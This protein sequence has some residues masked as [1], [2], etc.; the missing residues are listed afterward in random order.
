MS[1]TQSG[2]SD[3]ILA[4]EKELGVQLFIR[5]TRRVELTRAGAAFYER[6]VRILSEVS[7]KGDRPL[8]WWEV[9]AQDCDRHRLAKQSYEFTP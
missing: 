2:L 5:S 3:A 1:I 6:S 9:G 7:I 8:S 4:L